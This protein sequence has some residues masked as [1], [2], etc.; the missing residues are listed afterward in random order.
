MPASRGRKS[1]TV[2]RKK[3]S[4]T[5]VSERIDI[6]S[7]AGSSKDDSSAPVSTA[8]PVTFQ[9]ISANSYM[10]SGNTYHSLYPLY[11]HYPSFVPR[12]C[13]QQSSGASIHFPLGS[14]LSH[15][16][17]IVPGSSD[18]FPFPSS[19]PSL[20]STISSPS[21]MVESS[22][23]DLT[24]RIKKCYGCGNGFLK[25]SD[26]SVLEAPYDIV[27][28]HADYREYTTPSGEKR[29]TSQKQNTYF[30]PF[31]ACITKKHPQF[32]L[33]KFNFSSIDL[34]SEH[35]SLLR[36]TFLMK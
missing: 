32:S 15:G 13:Y 33:D 29:V 27:V 26:G 8:P 25:N 6:L 1:R 28:R 36:S 17:S 18:F 3:T 35:I 30:H 34:K 21:C 20:D 23:N 12:Q 10:Q 31:L 19:H 22:L 4:K 11:P 24:K 9:N 2:P 7:Q 16:A 14:P 5:Y